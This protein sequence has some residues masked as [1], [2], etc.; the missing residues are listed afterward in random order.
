MEPM[1]CCLDRFMLLLEYFSFMIYVCY[2][3][4]PLSFILSQLSLLAFQRTAE[5]SMLQ[6]T[7]AIVL[8]GFMA[9]VSMAQQFMDAH[10]FHNHAMGVAGM[11]TLAFNNGKFVSHLPSPSDKA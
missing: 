9:P 2:N 11:P 10:N 7:I 4:S 1:S 8:A 3:T 6:K 5:N